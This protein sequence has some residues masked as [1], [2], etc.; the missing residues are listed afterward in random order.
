MAT[1]Q[2]DKLSEAADARAVLVD[3]LDWIGRHPDLM[4]AQWVRTN[5]RGEPRLEPLLAPLSRSHD[6]VI[7]EYLDIDADELERERR[8]ILANLA[9]KES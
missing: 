5:D 9:T 4:L 6:A 1:S 7:F 8:D 2:I 3:F